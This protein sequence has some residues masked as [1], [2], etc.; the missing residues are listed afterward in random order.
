[1]FQE[2][3][4]DSGINKPSASG[5]SVFISNNKKLFII[6]LILIV[7]GVVVATTL[8]N[9]SYLKRKESPSNTTVELATTTNPSFL[10]TEVA[11]TTDDGSENEL[12]DHLE[13]YTFNDFYQEPK[14]IP[15]FNFKDYELPINSKI[16]ILNYY[17]TSRK[18]SLDASLSDL[19]SNGF[20]V[21]DLPDKNI[22][23]F[24]GVYDFLSRKEVPMLITTDF[25]LYRHQNLLKKAFK[26]IEENIFYENLHY[27]C[28]KLYESSKIR[29]EN[30]LAKIGNIN[31][32][33][34]EGERLAMA[35]FA[36][37]LKLLEP[38]A[39]QVDDSNKSNIK[40]SKS[41]AE[42]LYFN[43]LPYLQGDVGEEIKLI[44][45][46]NEVRK[47]PVLLYQKNYSDFVVPA[48]Y[49]RTEKLYNFYLASTWLNSIFP[50][51]VKDKNC[52]NCLLDNDDSRLS[53][54]AASFI[55]QDF[56][57]NQELKNRWAVIY[58]I[59]SYSKGLRD[60]LT[61]LHYDSAIKESFGE[62]A[63]LEEVFSGAKEDIDQNLKKL[64]DRLLL[65]S[66]NDAQGALDK[67]SEKGKIGFRLLSDYYWPNNYI[68]NRLSGEK[69]GEYLDNWS[70][71]NHLTL[72]KYSK[73]RCNGFSLD[74][75][76]LVARRIE[77][78]PFWSKNT[79]FTNYLSEFLSLQSEINS[80]QI[81]NNNNFWSTMGSI[82]LMFEDNDNQMQ[83]YSRQE[84]WFNRLIN[85]GVGSWI[86]LQLPLEDFSLKSVTGNIGLNNEAPFSENFYVE[87]NYALVQKLIADNE[88]I[89]GMFDI[90]GVNKKLNLVSVSIKEENTNLKKV[91]DIIE[92][93]L[94]G[95][96]LSA[97]DY[98]FM[99]T[100]VGEYEL[101]QGVANQ[102]Y[103]K[104]GD[105]GLYE[106]L[107]IKLVALVYESGAGKFLAVGPI[108][109]YQERRQ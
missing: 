85:S 33:V 39:H 104:S 15:R 36:V 93:E 89:D 25:L 52:V 69:I 57:A 76:G 68:F 35:Y 86:N 71:E 34:L 28:K 63:N 14:S 109:S 31:D 46:A 105:F 47:S 56:S 102:L 87:P 11:S 97:D 1:M 5:I 79:N 23:N 61:Y 55:T 94:N 3:S 73:L 19:N 59:M 95:E 42:N 37:A 48:E 17:D 24:Y 9:S 98:K 4:N 106:N 88:M 49:R 22:S 72:C 67:D 64:R 65:F 77:A 53:L 2:E 18:I 90:L 7:F 108:F 82:R 70:N 43:I 12:S 101:K 62:Q 40:F 92:K 44:K 81:W 78:S 74:I 30:R 21:L 38:E 54:I 8:I 50:L 29:Y 107:N 45:K 10:P 75:I 103:L 27:I 91:L 99:N 6:F 60:G 51:I 58:K 41:E 100:F 66:F 13:K 26:D 20:A 84:A 32:S 96:S 16:D 80:S 83:A